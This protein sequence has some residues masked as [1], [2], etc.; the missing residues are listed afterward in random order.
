MRTDRA[1][2]DRSLHF[3]IE[4]AWRSRQGHILAFFFALFVVCC[5]VWLPLLSY[6][7]PNKGWWDW[8]EPIAGIDYKVLQKPIAAEAPAG[9]ALMIE[10]FGY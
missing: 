5:I 10:F 1:T 6:T 7:V 9:K 4:Y 2:V 8:A 3:L